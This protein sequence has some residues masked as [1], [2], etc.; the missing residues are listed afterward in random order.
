VELDYA[1]QYDVPLRSVITVPS[2]NYLERGTVSAVL[3]M[4][5]CIWVLIDAME[6]A[7]PVQFGGM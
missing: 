5:P 6:M 7:L 1:L 3:G 4:D 2:F